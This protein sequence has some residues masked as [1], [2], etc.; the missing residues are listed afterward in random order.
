MGKQFDVAMDELFE[1]G[2]EEGNVLSGPHFYDYPALTTDQQ[3][4]VEE[5]MIAVAQ[6]NMLRGK[7]KPSY[8]NNNLSDAKYCQTYKDL[9]C[10]HYHCGPTYNKSHY[11]HKFTYD[12]KLNLYGDTSDE[13]IHY[14]KITDEVSGEVSILI[15]GFAPL[16][17]EP[18]FPPSDDPEDPHPLFQVVK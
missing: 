1:F 6:G 11:L 18:R 5:F 17:T 9:E 13:V 4:A 16:H 15:L 12:L 8:L 10:W 7:N 2:D 14:R 3:S